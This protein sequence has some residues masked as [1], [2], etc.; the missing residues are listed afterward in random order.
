MPDGT[1]KSGR[2]SK[3]Q[4][5]LKKLNLLFTI[6]I[7]LFILSCSPEDNDV[8]QSQT[9]QLITIEQRSFYNG[10]LGERIIIDYTN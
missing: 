2:Q 10:A 8:P 5:Q 4:S 1:Q 7:W 9:A 3:P 6:I